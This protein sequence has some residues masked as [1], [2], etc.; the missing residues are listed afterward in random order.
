MST[1][2]SPWGV[3]ARHAYACAARCLG[4][5]QRPFMVYVVA[6]RC[7]LCIVW[8]LCPHKQAVSKLDGVLPTFKLVFLNTTLEYH[9][10]NCAST[11]WIETILWDVAMQLEVFSIA[12]GAAE[13]R[14]GCVRPVG[15]IHKASRVM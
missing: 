2:S 10:S 13:T 6:A 9:E 3:R 11:L 8:F 15:S 5:L 14:C 4:A 7:R 12:I 1:T